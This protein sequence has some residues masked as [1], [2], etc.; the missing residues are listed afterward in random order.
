MA[1]LGSR[2]RA[3]PVDLVIHAPR[4]IIDGQEQGAT[5]AGPDGPD[6]RH[7]AVGASPPSKYVATLNPTR[8]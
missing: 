6:R 2:F 7:R 5:V 8:C 4:A 1:R 3:R